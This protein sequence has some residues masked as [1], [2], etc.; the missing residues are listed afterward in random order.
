MRNISPEKLIENALKEILQEKSSTI[1][2]PIFSLFSK[3]TKAK[4]EYKK[5]KKEPKEG[6]GASSAGSFSP[7]INFNE[8]DDEAQKIEATEATGASSSGSFEGASFLAKNLDNW[9]PSKKT[10][11][12]GGM[13]VKPKEKCKTFPY[14]NQ[15]DI[16]SLDFS[17]TSN[18]GMKLTKKTLKKK[19]SKLK[20]A[21]LNVSYKTGL[22][23]EEIL[24]IL[25]DNI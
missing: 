25:I 17:K 8:E 15:G 11:L 5:I 9:G 24:K 21:I 18:F 12:P 23:E 14:C 2:R 10:Q 1:S 13:F 4:K 6:M 22:T 16:N 19:K 20:E 7:A 3:D